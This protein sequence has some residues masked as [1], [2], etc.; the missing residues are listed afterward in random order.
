MF[1]KNYVGSTNKKLS[2]HGVYKPSILTYSVGFFSNI[3]ET[4][5]EKRMFDHHSRAL[6]DGGR[7]SPTVDYNFSFHPWTGD[8]TWFFTLIGR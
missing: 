4:A 2:V 1:M 6:S 8:F 3:W 7:L 5:A